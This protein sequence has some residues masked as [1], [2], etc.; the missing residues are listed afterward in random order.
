MRLPEI[1]NRPD[2]VP[3]IGNL[4][5]DLLHESLTP[6][7]DE[8]VQNLPHADVA[9]LQKSRQFYEDHMRLALSAA[10]QIVVRSGVGVVV[11]A[12]SETEAWESLLKALIEAGWKVTASWPIDTEMGSR[13]LSQRQRTLTSS[14][15]LVHLG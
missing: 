11:F 9:H 8:C 7:D 3:P 15:H 2:P 14:I 13:I 5:P 4:F 6:K 10:S 1:I 12:H